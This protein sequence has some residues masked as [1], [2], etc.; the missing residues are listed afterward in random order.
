MS[1]K[2]IVVA[3]GGSS[4]SLYAKVLFDRLLQLKSNWEN[5]GVV[6]TENGKYNWK[7]ELG[8]EEWRN[9][10]FEY[11]GQREFTAPFASG[12]AQYGTMII[13]PCSMGLM[14][15]IASGISTDLI[16]RAA[17]VI[18]KERRRLILVPREAPYSLIHLRNMTSITEAGGIICPAVPSFYGK[19]DTPEEIVRTVVD[20]VLDLAGFELED[21]FR[22]GSGEDGY[23][24]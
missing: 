23:P 20:R 21:T 8:D 11:Y 19:S 4:G 22:W 7:F 3:V 24:G 1:R 15:R 2:K 12:S 18:L 6:I 14:A 9:Y 17:D 10:G 13:C 5:V 16:T